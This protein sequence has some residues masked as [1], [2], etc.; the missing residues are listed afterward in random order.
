MTQSG[1]SYFLYF[2]PIPGARQIFDLTVDLVQISCGK[3]VPFFDYVE[4][5]ESLT[6]WA[7]KQGEKGLKDYWQKKNQK[8]ID[9]KP[10]NIM[11]KNA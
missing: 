9:G 10:T 8:S 5:R 1:I 7:T 11:D 2:P 4:E 6:D 3:A